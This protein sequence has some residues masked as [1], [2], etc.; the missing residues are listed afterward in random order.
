MR[1][2]TRFT[3]PRRNLKNKIKRF[4]DFAFVSGYFRFFGNQE[5]SS[6]NQDQAIYRLNT[7]DFIFL[8]TVVLGGII[9]NRGI[10]NKY[11]FVCSNGPNSIPNALH[12]LVD[13][14]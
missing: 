8:S 6:L 10:S 12:G 14:T 9:K 13:I 11:I 5:I 4:L 2:E 1:V 3:L 7:L